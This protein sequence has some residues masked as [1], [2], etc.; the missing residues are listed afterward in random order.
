[1]I[2]KIVGGVD[3]RLV[4]WYIKGMLPGES[5]V[6]SRNELVLGGAVLPGSRPQMPEFQ[7][8]IK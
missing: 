1:M 5:F 3:C 7:E 6:I 8:Y 4:G 2:K